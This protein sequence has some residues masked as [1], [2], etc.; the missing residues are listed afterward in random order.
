VGKPK[1]GYLRA[2][3][4]PERKKKKVK[5]KKK[6]LFSLNSFFYIYGVKTNQ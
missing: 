5:N 2:E 3:E 6:N 4:P 1:A